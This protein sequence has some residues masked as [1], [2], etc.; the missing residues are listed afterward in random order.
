MPPMC[1]PPVGEGAK[2][3]PDFFL[4]DAKIGLVRPQ[5][6]LFACLHFLEVFANPAKLIA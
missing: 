2:A 6:N 4:H 3:N 1:K 5:P